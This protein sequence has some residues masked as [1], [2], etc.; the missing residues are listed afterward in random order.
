MK[1]TEMN[2]LQGPL[3]FVVLTIWPS[4]FSILMWIFYS[5]T[6][7]ALELH[8]S[9]LKS[10]RINLA[11]ISAE[12]KLSRE[13]IAFLESEPGHNPIVSGPDSEKEELRELRNF[14]CP[15][16]DNSVA[17]VMPFH[18]GNKIFHREWI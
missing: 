13:K 14:V 9:E 2:R 3:L 7:A 11:A 5:Q 17:I 10:E 4:I 8:A 18:T 15:R 6:K 12:W 1:R 16:W